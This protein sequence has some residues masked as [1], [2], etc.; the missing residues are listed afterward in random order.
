M[1]I[2]KAKSKPPQDIGRMK[3][4]LHS[5]P[6][7]GKSTWAA[8][9]PDSIF[10]ATEPGLGCIEAMRWE[11]EKGNYV[12]DTWTKLM[13]ATREVVEA[14][15]FKTVIIDTLDMALEM[16]KD[17]ICERAGEKYHT[18]G[19]LSYG[20]GSAMIIAEMRR[21]LV[22]LGSI[23]MGVILLAHTVQET[24]HGRTGE[25]QK[26][27]PN[28]PEK[29]RRPILGMMDLILYGDFEW[30]KKGDER[31]CRRVVRTKPAP[32]WEAGDRSARLPVSMGLDWEAMRKAFAGSDSTEPVSSN[33]Q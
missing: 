18:D 27:V 25:Y 13:D 9:I 33:K 26:A 5:F 4:L 7:F 2:P 28:V 24:I 8:S 30:E 14:G 15:C 11:D 22:R 16:C 17:H 31:I 19:T 23:N 20:K 3:V 21:Y 29:H 6:K 12:I 1:P 32:V 10:L